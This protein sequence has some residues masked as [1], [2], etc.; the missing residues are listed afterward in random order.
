MNPSKDLQQSV[1]DSEPDGA[2]QVPAEKTSSGLDPKNSSSVHEAIKP[3]SLSKRASSNLDLIRG[4]AAVVVLLGHWR[5]LFFR[6]FESLHQRGIFLKAFYFLTGLGHQAVVVFFVLSGFFVGGSVNRSFRLGR[7]S[8]RKYLLDRLTRLYLV[9]GPAL[10]LGCLLDLLGSR[11]GGSN[12]IY[13]GISEFSALIPTSVSPDLTPTVFAGNLAFLQT[14]TVPTLGT[15][16]ALWSLANEFWYYILFPLL[17]LVL[18][19]R[20]SAL[21]R[22]V[23]AAL[24]G[25]VVFFIGMRIAAFFPVWLIGALIAVK[26][27]S[28]R[29]IGARGLSFVLPIAFLAACLFLPKPTGLWTLAAHDLLLGAITGLFVANLAS[30]EEQEVR[31]LIRKLS[32]ALSSTSYTLYLVHLPFAVLLA[33]LVI[34]T[35]K[36]W[37]PSPLSF[38]WG[39]LII[40]L[41]AAYAGVV[42][43]LFERNLNKFRSVVYPLAGQSK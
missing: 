19:K 43:W 12:S 42:W 35:G 38:V 14:I 10:V 13:G 15:N 6:D 16:G 11:L 18:Y 34:G 8:W 7:W 28:S 41:V 32:H 36:R 9:L 24:M 27:I 31:P 21:L 4:L 40:G 30:A 2:N 5:Y 17:C 20:S 1:M 3:P 37:V 22:C 33:S 39:F 25:L 29:L 23:S 26:P